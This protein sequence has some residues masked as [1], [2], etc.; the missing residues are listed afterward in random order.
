MIYS[1]RVNKITYESNPQ[2]LPSPK[3]PSLIIS[4]DYMLESKKPVPKI[5]TT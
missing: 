1:P 3:E 2:P 4:T 5:L